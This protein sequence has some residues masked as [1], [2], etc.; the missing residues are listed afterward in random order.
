MKA[1]ILS[2]IFVLS[3]TCV[4]A[5]NPKD[6]VKLK[7]DLEAISRGK[8]VQTTKRQSVM[9]SR[10]PRAT[11]DTLALKPGLRTPTPPSP[12]NPNPYD[13]VPSVTNAEPPA[14][15]VPHPVPPAGIPSGANGSPKKKE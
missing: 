8:E 4:A 12:N 13:P 10:T 6:S 14:T 3:V 7:A 11:V 5:Q 1:I 2:S 15:P 9:R